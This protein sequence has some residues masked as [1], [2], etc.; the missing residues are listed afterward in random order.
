MRKFALF[1][2]LCFILC[3]PLSYAEVSSGKTITDVRVKGNLTIGTPTVLSKVETKTGNIF[4]QEVINDDIKRLYELG[5]FVDVAFDVEEEE[6]GVIVTIIVEE[7]PVVKEILIEGNTQ[8]RTARL[9][10]SMKIKEGDML[11]FSQLTEDRL[12]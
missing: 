9:K 11:Q 5:Y 7:K 2:F 4:S 6:K 3:N 1:L 10:K 12:R 8:M